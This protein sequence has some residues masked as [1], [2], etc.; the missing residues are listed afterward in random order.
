MTIFYSNLLPSGSVNQGRSGVYPQ[1]TRGIVTIPSGTTLVAADTIQLFQVSS[2]GVLYECHIDISGALESGSAGL[3]GVL[4]DNLASP[5]VY[6]ATGAVVNAAGTTFQGILR[7]GGLGTLAQCG[8]AGRFGVLAYGSTT[9]PAAVDPVIQILLGGTAGG[10]TAAIR[11][12]QFWALT[13]NT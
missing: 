5:N 1:I 13:M 12:I 10:A 9:T 8:T 2:P 6:V 11:T 3:T 7:A 4:E